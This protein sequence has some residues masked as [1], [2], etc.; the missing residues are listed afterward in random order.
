MDNCSAFSREEDEPELSNEELIKKKKIHVTV[1]IEIT[2]F[3]KQRLHQD[4]E[5][6]DTAV[7]RTEVRTD[8]S[9]CFFELSLLTLL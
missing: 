2:K 4:V 3:L 9:F 6:F 8:I 1:R 5:L 7:L